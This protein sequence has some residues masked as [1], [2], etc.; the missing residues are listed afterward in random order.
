[1]DHE[2]IVVCETCP[3]DVGHNNRCMGNVRLNLH[4]GAETL[5]IRSSMTVLSAVCDK[6]HILDL[7]EV[8]F[9]LR[10]MPSRK[11]LYPLQSQS[12]SKL[13]FSKGEIQ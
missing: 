7:P 6:A 1:M 9:V 4:K 3:V 10:V 5:A 12:S 2:E 13:Q 11:V 8:E